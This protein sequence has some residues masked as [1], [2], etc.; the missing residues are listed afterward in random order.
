MKRANHLVIAFSLF[1]LGVGAATPAK[2][3]TI[4]FSFDAYNFVPFMGDETPPF[5]SVF[6]SFTID[7]DPNASVINTPLVLNS[8]HIPVTGSS[9]YNYSTTNHSLLVGA[10]GNVGGCNSSTNDFIFTVINF[11]TAPTFL[12]FFILTSRQS[13]IFR[14]YEPARYLLS[15]LARC[16]YLPHFRSSP[17]AS[18][19][20][21]YSAGEGNGKLANYQN[22]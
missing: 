10:N 15:L 1:A 22:R 11:D 21:V 17:L 8:I 3:A 4:T 7:F 16:L 13:A 5:P 18:A 9:L 12:E 2:S 20:C 14:E 6:G 19:C